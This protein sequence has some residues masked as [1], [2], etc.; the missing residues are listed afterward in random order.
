M[1]PRKSEVSQEN[2]IEAFAA[3]RKLFEGVLRS[4]HE[5]KIESC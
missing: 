1:S 3:T 5:H 2:S 4:Y